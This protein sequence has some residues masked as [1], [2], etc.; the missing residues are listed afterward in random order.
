MPERLVRRLDAGFRRF[1]DVRRDFAD[2]R[3]DFLDFVFRF[4]AMA[5]PPQTIL[6][7]PSNI[8]APWFSRGQATSR[9]RTA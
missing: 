5:S 9:N 6:G 7:S 1:A 2:V 8:F 4:L 3:R